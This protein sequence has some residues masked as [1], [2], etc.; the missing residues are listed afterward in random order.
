VSRDVL[1]AVLIASGIYL[2]SLFVMVRS[3]QSR[4]AFYD[5]LLGRREER[6]SE[7][8]DRLQA[9]NLSEFRAHRPVAMHTPDAEVD[10]DYFTDPT[11]LVVERIARDR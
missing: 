4:L 10:Y 7:L 8:E 2:F 9:A 3:Y 11:G 5:D 6:V 1:I